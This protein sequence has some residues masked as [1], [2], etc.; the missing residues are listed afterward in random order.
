MTHEFACASA[1]VRGGS[2]EV[3][4]PLALRSVRNPQGKEET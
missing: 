4:A 1:S 3:G 2:S